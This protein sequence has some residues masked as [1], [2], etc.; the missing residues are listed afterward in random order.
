PEVEPPAT[1]TSLRPS[2]EGESLTSRHEP[3][4][5]GPTLE[6]DGAAKREAPPETR[7]IDVDAV[8][9]VPPPLPG[10][11]AT[12]KQDAPIDPVLPRLQIRR[13]ESGT[14]SPASSDGITLAAP[15]P[16]LP[17]K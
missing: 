3:P 7:L 8:P 4:R 15:E 6:P 14:A 13:V 1:T 11:G 16:G 17:T 2:P 12:G 9:E 10:A 5:P